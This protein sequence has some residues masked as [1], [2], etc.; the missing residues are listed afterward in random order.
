L[1]SSLN[2][3]LRK[4]TEWPCKYKSFFEVFETFISE[5][6]R[7]VRNNFQLMIHWWLWS[8][9]LVISKLVMKCYCCVKSACGL[10]LYIWK[11][12]I[13]VKFFF[14]I[15]ICK[16]F[17]VKSTMAIYITSE[18]SLWRL[19]TTQQ[20]TWVVCVQV[21][22]LLPTLTYI[23]CPPS[24]NVGNKTTLQIDAMVVFQVRRPLLCSIIYRIFI[25][26]QPNTTEVITIKRRII[27]LQQHVFS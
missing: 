27:F 18:Y 19:G 12:C 22:H 15:Y 6:F 8:S 25:I 24:V 2:S 13:Y 17:L 16:V 20:W 14:Y 11:F 10:F 3:W 5:L 21:G 9:W 7:N 26:A 1:L 4:L 23:M